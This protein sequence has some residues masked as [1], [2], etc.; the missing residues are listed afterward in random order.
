MMHYDLESYDEGV[1]GGGGDCDDGKSGKI[2]LRYHDAD[3]GKY[4]EINYYFMA[5][6]LIII[7]V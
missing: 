2:L 7:I 1:D 3:M 4:N 6:I 5:K